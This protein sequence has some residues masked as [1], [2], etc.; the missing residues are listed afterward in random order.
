[1]K[2]VFKYK[3][4]LFLKLFFSGPKLI[5]TITFIPF[6][7][8]CGWIL[9]FPTLLIGIEKESLSL[10]G[11]IITFL[12]FVFL[13]PKWFQTRWNLTNTWALLGINKIDK[14]S[15]L[16]LY[17]LRGFIISSILVSLI[18]ITIIGTQWG[19]WIGKIYPDIFFNAILLIIGIGFAE[20]LIFRG[21]LLEELKNQFGLKNAIVGQALVFSIVH[22]GF[23]LPFWQM[24][25]ILTG[26]FLLGILLAFIR[27]NDKSSLWGC[28]GLHG[29]LVG[30]WFLTNNG[31]LEISEDAPKWL[32]GPGSLNT[33]PL[34]GIFGIFL[35]IIF[36]FFY[37]KRVKKI[38]F[39]FR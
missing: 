11:T 33:N 38:F 7:Y 30:L 39:S 26:L 31:L 18:L 22:I 20:E 37:F 17:F 21:W 9:A 34:G 1:M 25:S 13:L 16:I 12:I 28:I 24:I 35:M 10:I 14:N 8:I 19:S 5:S 27:L 15:K 4:N 3:K 32:V 2:N 23:D 6:L 29:G 36:C